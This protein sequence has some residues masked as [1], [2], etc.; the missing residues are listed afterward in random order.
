MARLLDAAGYA[1]EILDEPP[2]CGALARHVGEGHRADLL[3]DR[4][5]QALAG[6]RGIL[7]PT[8]AGCGAHLQTVLAT[9][10]IEVQD[11]ATALEAGPRRLR[12]RSGDAVTVAFQ[13]P[14]H[15]RHGMGV[16]EAPRNLLRAAGATLVEPGEPDLC[17]GSAGSYNL[18][19]GAM[20]E[21]LGRRKC[22]TLE[23]TGAAVAVTAN[24]GCA[25]QLEAYLNR[26]PV[27]TLAR[28]LESRLVA[29]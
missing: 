18:V 19:F 22:A 9:G 29:E 13:D 21:R 27:M 15:L 20:S 3:H 17:C 4:L 26:I 23:A 5:T 25:I 1:V 16:V 6:R 2:C 7:V 28:F 12:F 11:L 24:P 14:C 10:A 8:A